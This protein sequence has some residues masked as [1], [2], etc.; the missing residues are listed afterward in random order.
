MIF[1][2]FNI[3]NVNDFIL[4]ISLT[5][6]IYDTDPTSYYY[7]NPRNCLNVKN[8]VGTY[9]FFFFKWYLT[10]SNRNNKYV[11]Y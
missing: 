4:L 7:F 3:S 2:L 1:I 8:A 5:A 11:E 6:L 10:W 9:S